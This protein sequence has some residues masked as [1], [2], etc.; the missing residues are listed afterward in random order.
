MHFTRHFSFLVSAFVILSSTSNGQSLVHHVIQ[1]LDSLS[2]I[3]FDNWRYSTDRLQP[4]YRTD[5]N[6]SSWE[7][8]KINQRVYPDTA[9]L[10]KVIVLPERVLGTPMAGEV[11]LLL[12]VDDGGLVWINEDFKGRFDWNGEYVLTDSAK[13]GDRFIV[14]IKAINTGGPMRLLRAELEVER[15][16]A[17][18]A[19]IRDYITSLRV[20]EKLL[21]NDTYQTS[22]RLKEDPGTDK[23]V[24]PKE[25]KD[26]VRGLL[27]TAA[28]KVRLTDLSQGDVVGFQNSLEDCK[29]ALAPVDSFA[30]KFTLIFDSNAHID[31]AWLWRWQETVEVCKNTF[32]AVLDM[33]DARP[34]FTYTQS[35]AQYYEWM[36]KLYPDVFRRIS[37][38]VKDGR[39]E[40]VGGMWVEPDC[41]LPSGESWFHHLLL[42]NEY[43]QKKL[44]VSVKIGWNPDSF[45]YN[46]NMPQFYKQAGIDD[47]VTQKIGWNDTDVFPYR[48]FWW[49]AP[50]G[51]R[52]LA[53]FPYDYVNTI[54]DPF[55]F[56]DQLRQ[57]EANT[58]YRTLLVLFGVGDH[59]GGPDNAMLDRVLALKKLPVYP[60]VE[61]GKTS[62]Y[63]SWVR[64]HDLTSVPVWKDELYL[65]Y[66]RGTFTTQ[67]NTKEYNRRL[68]S[69]LNTTAKF[70]SIASLF[71]RPYN[72]E[73]L[74]SA[75]R[76]VMFNQFH[77]ILPGSGI[78][79]N[80]IDAAKRYRKAEKLAHFELQKSLAAV[81]QQINTRTVGHGQAIV[82]FNPLAWD[83]TDVVNVRLPEGD[84]SAYSVFALNGKEQLSQEVTKG[85]LDR[86]ILFVAESVPALG[87]KVYELRK[88]KPSTLK[89]DVAASGNAIENRFFN[90]T[91]NRD[92]GWV[93]SIFDKTNTREIL[94]GGH[95]NELQI[96][97]DKPSDWDA[98][99]IGLTGRRWYP[100]VRSVELVERGPVRAVLR[101]KMDYLKPGVKKDF[102]TPDFPSTFF[103][104]DIILYSGL[105]RVDFKTDVDWWEDRTMLKVA[106]PVTVTDPV[107]TYEIPY[108]HITRSVLNRTKWEKARFEVPAERWA[109]LSQ[110]DYGVSLI[111]QSKY[112]YDIKGNVMR[113]SLL[114]SPK[115][116]DP[117]ADRGEHVIEYSIYGHKGGW[118]EGKTVQRGYELNTPLIPVL[119]QPRRGK[120]PP[121]GSF[122]RC[123]PDNI[124]LTVV[125]KAEDSD[126]Y[127]LQLYEATGKDTTATITLPHSARRVLLSN[128]LEEDGAPLDVKNGQISLKVGKNQ[129]VTM[130][131]FF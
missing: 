72:R 130:K 70:S 9:W 5:Y 23:S 65:E 105:D 58:G 107:A 3:Q 76:E 40:V 63:F 108:G 88:K 103:T 111:N 89:S 46:W 99:N 28:G 97:E 122:F 116:P 48:L 55:L 32:A 8:L 14:A 93:E 2:R 96:L 34:D 73:N 90:V 30:K 54:D 92:S 21:S 67:A 19:E 125:K 71:G 98:W 17:F 42:S 128:F 15:T 6:D 87:Y 1:D 49:E 43:F 56:A 131:V 13:A 44:G 62:D 82:V 29:T 7:T 69:L 64:K 127:V 86:N 78:R 60:N 24:I 18:A 102:P 109:D 52:V 50:D 4:A 114:R 68:E 91:V 85:V 16:K 95:G 12:T 83:R 106:F 110:S 84:S 59:G 74:E 61:F 25:E 26:R 31:A 75:W 51:S 36:E 27:D 66:H 80:Y 104:Q 120:L 129:I 53:Y 39:W 38:R 22:A 121:A 100:K 47:F 81:V 10:R 118:E 33:M 119:V 123:E 115:W 117:T 101:V 11:K 37:Q 79:E 112:G 20:A 41:N 45:G 35:S 124:V 113:L 94:S 126:A 57:F 77:D